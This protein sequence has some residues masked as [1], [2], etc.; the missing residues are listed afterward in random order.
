MTD[1]EERLSEGS[2]VE[3][4][5]DALACAGRRRC[6]QWAG[7]LWHSARFEFG[8]AQLGPGKRGTARLRLQWK[9]RTP[10]RGW[11][12]LGQMY[13]AQQ[14]LRSVYLLLAVATQAWHRSVDEVGD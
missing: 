8:D 13:G 9:L 10:A 2:A 11:V 14:P 12:R 4:I 3:Q 7:V 6:A 5:L 1:V